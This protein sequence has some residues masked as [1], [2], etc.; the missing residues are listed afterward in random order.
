MN[1]IEASKLMKNEKVLMSE[2]TRTIYEINGR[3]ILL[4]D[5]LMVGEKYLTDKEIDG[6]W[7]EVKKSKRIRDIIF[8][9]IEV[10]IRPIFKGYLLWLIFFCTADA[11]FAGS[12]SFLTNL[13]RS[14]YIFLFGYFISK[15]EIS[16]KAFNISFWI[17]I[18]TA[19]VLL[20]AMGEYKFVIA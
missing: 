2:V 10:I 17:S 18:V 16:D 6:E 1:Y 8:S 12:N 5:G 14:L 15:D 19:S 7:T 9:K 13:F 11:F 4:A 3:G 20:L